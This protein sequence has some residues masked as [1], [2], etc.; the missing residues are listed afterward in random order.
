M[1][2]D[3]GNLQFMEK[4]IVPIADTSILAYDDIKSELGNKQKAILDIIGYLGSCT[5]SEIA[6]FSG[7]TI[8]RVTPRVLELRDKGFVILDCKKE[9]PVTGRLAMAWRRVVY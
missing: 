6:R 7:I 1:G 3:Q 9:C 2:K 5:N 4:K 8:N